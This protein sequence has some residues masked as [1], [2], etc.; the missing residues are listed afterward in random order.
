MKRLLWTGIPALLLLAAACRSND[1]G[2][3]AN[4]VDREF[5]KPAPEVWK[6]SVKSVEAMDLKVSSDLHDRFG[7]ELVAN[8]AS[9]EE[10]RVWVRSLDQKRSQVSVRVEPGDRPLAHLL[11]ERIAE[12]LGLG[13]ARSGL[14]GG[15]STEGCYPMDLGTAMTTARRT[16]RSLQVTITDH[17]SHAEWAKIDGRMQDSTPVRIRIDKVDEEKLNVT[18]IAGN[19][20]S[21]DNKAFATRMKEEFETLTHVKGSS[22]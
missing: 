22:D 15:N 19:E 17:E 7:G 11:Q 21:E 13:E 2:S 8:R 10:V 1:L 20:K 4:T 18:F 5:A 9:G 12:K 14:L 16:L 3:G 6:A